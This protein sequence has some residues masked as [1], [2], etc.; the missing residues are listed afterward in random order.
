MDVK[1][2]CDKRFGVITTLLTRISYWPNKTF[3]KGQL[4]GMLFITEMQLSSSD[5]SNTD[6]VGGKYLSFIRVLYKLYET[7]NL[8][9]QNVNWYELFVEILYL[10]LSFL[11]ILH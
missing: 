5:L 9:L 11:L 4:H 7:S 3:A 6:L 8:S 10:L 1:A 2:M